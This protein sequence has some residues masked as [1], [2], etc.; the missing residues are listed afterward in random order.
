[1]KDHTRII[2]IVLAVLALTT[3]V[4][5]VLNWQYAREKAALLE[6]A[7]IAVLDNGS[8]VYRL[9]SSEI[10]QL[11]TSEFTALLKSSLMKSPEAHN[12]TG[13]ALADLFKAAQLS[14]EGKKR[15]MVRSADGYTVPL[16]I[17]EIKAMDNIYL[18]YRDNGRYLGSYRDKGGQG[19]YM[20]VIKGDRFSQR[21]A[22]Y[23]C[24]LDVQ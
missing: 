13:I 24:E 3:A 12:Y 23:V 6:A 17:E 20:I 18:V 4:G 9:T 11:P 22:K 7:E 16:A 19:P 21:W 2:V 14:L 5:A 8:E 1:M 10:S 15:V